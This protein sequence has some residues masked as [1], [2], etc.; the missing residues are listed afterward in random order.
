MSRCEKNYFT[1]F[2]FFLLQFIKK[3]DMITINRA[4]KEVDAI[5]R[6]GRTTTH[7]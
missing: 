6:A 1:C 3:Y 2:M 7:N 4:M 5:E